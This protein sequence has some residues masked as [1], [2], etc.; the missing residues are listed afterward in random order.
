MITS[1]LVLITGGSRGLGFAAARKFARTGFRVV[2]TSRSAARA[3]EA[4]TTLRLET[5]E[6]VI[7]GMALDLSSLGN[8][9][10]FAAELAAQEDALHVLV[11]NA[12]NLPANMPN[13]KVPEYTAE[14]FETTFATNHLG[15]DCKVVLG[16]IHR[17]C[18]YAVGLV[19]RRIKAL[20]P[21]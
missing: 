3:D 18:Y 16:C 5:P 21:S 15:R 1:K 9:R 19:R 4:A 12:A 14:G 8:V 17:G 10:A 7:R 13:A 11:A 2:L 6:A 20:R